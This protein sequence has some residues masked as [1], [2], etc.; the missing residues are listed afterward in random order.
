MLVQSF[1]QSVLK[2]CIDV[3]VMKSTKFMQRVQAFEAVH[4]CHPVSFTHVNLPIGPRL[5]PLI[6]STGLPFTTLPIQ[7]R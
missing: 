3:M 6:T 2:A 4:V 1:Q 5:M 7:A